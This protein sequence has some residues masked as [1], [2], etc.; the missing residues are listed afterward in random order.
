MVRAFIG[1]ILPDDIKGYAIGMQKKLK[2]LP[3][4]A[5]FV[6]PDNL[7]IS[8]S[9]LGD[10]SDGEVETIKLKL[11]GISKSYEKFEITI[12]GI[13]L[14]PNEKF[15]RVI[16]LDVGSSILE[17]LRKKIVEN[18]GGKSHP[19]HLTLARVNVITEKI[20]F[21]E[22]INSVYP[23]KIVFKADNV[24]LIKSELRRDGPV[25]VTLHKSYLK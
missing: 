24:N 23:K 14:I 7:H 25:Y 8:L 9:F 5:K 10:I 18:I 12:G 2:A 3:M 22:N 13:S 15:I 11:D 1:V 16:A 21:I 19:A 20:K 6:E 17:S 4:K